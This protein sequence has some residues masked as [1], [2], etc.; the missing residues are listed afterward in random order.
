[1]KRILFHTFCSSGALSPYPA[2]SIFYIDNTLLVSSGSEI[3]FIKNQIEIKSKCTPVSINK[4]WGTS[5]SDLYIVGNGG[6]IAHYDGKGW[7]RIGSGTDLNIQDIW[8]SVNPFTGETEILCVASDIYYN[9]GSKLLKIKHKK[10]TE[11]NKNGLSWSLSGVWFMSGLKYIVVGDGVNIYNKNNKSWMEI[12]EFPKFFTFGISGASPNNIFVCGSSGLLGHFNGNT[13]KNYRGR[14]TPA[15]DGE[16]L[17][18]DNIENI[19]V[20]CGYIQNR[21]ALILGRREK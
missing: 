20:A 16:Y 14:E 21:A 4:I 6:M 13:W 17:K 2:K 1:M 7:T 8:G 5:S 11:I 18:C 9:R 19:M 10:V 12:P 15:I 3:I